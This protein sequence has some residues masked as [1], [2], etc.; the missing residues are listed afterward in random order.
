MNVLRDDAR[1][2]CRVC[3]RHV[4]LDDSRVVRH[5]QTIAFIP[6]HRHT[7]GVSVALT[8][9]GIVSRRRLAQG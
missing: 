3:H 4:V 6:A 8:V 5:A 9:K 1:I 7:G 2:E